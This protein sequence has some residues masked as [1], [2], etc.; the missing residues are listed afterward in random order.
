MARF[1]SS[2]VGMLLPLLLAACDV[3]AAA[4]L[5]T[6]AA[7]PATPAPSRAPDWTVP[8]HRIGV[9][10]VEGTGE[11]YDRLSSERFVVRGANYAFVPLGD[12]RYELLLLKDGVYDG[13]RTRQDFTRM[14]ALG[15]NTVR[16]F[17]DHCTKGPGCIGDSDN[18][19]LNPA[20]L[21]NIADLMAA[22]R[23]AGL[24]VL[25]TS[26]DLP[27][28][29][30]YAEEAN[31]QSGATFGGYRNSYY[32][33]PGAISGT[34]RYWRD[35]LTG[36]IE[37]QAAFD[38]VLAWELV[39]EQWMF[40]DQPPLSLTSG[41]VETTTGAYDMADPTQK[42]AMVDEGLIHYI[43]QMRD[44]ILTHD[45]TALVTMGFFAPEI[46]APGWYLRTSRLLTESDLDFFDFHAYPGGP[47]LS[48]YP[49]HF[50]MEGYTAKPIVLGEYG[51]FRQ[52][53]A[54]IE[55]A[56]RAVTNWAAESCSHGFD[57]WLYWTYWPANPEVGDRTWGLTDE[58]GYLLDLLAPVHQPDPC[59]AVTVAGGNIAYGKPVDASASLPAEPPSNAV[60]ESAGTQWG[61]GGDA[62]QWLEVDLEGVYRVT[63]VRLLVAQYPE[64]PTI[65]RVYLRRGGN[66]EPANE[67]S[68]ETRP[69]DWLLLAPAVPFDNVTAVRVDTVSS[70]SWV[71][72][73][74]I[75]VYGD[76][77]Q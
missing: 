45:P 37:R 72:W 75:Q 13:A 18:A 2:L 10:S 39:N 29:G 16:V 17:L 59:E 64:G 41:L 40:A 15:Y 25:F 32:L 43:T 50:G 31:A 4:L 76:A 54:T 56:A 51:P 23:E 63:E 3:P 22:A 7:A 47:P 30:G 11:L 12:G 74:E 61:S 21:D 28:Q 8:D 24:V 67:F 60:D 55:S 52:Y 9:H 19:G 14:A 58:D 20:Y 35:L 6:R 26:N 48:E 33:T 66:W 71:A 42:E 77:M 53:Y 1:R 57:G 73:S 68:G 38:A 44:E 34:R 5:P 69:G 70:P 27:D 46:A 65:H 62:P 36:L 49:S